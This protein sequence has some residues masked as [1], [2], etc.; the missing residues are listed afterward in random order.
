[1]T[2]Q[3]RFKLVEIRRMAN[4]EETA[5]F[6]FNAA[7]NDGK[8]NESWSKATPSGQITITVTNPSA[9]AAFELGKE[10]QLTFA[11]VAA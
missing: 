10:Y 4:T 1:M 7:Y 8:G 5:E 11:P 3:A 9:I 6:K 2:I